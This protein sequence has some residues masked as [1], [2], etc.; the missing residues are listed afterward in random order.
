MNFRTHVLVIGGGPA[1][2]VAA[3]FLASHGVDTLLVERNLAFVKPCGGGIPYSAFQEL[4][5]PEYPVKR[6]VSELKVVSPGGETLNITLNGGSIAIVERGDFDRALRAEAEA[7]GATILEAEFMGFPDT[8][9]TVTA[10]V[11]SR[12]PGG[13]LRRMEVRAD[14]VIAA[15]GVNSRVRAATNIRP[16]PCFLTLSERIRGEYSDA[17]E[18]WFGSSHA[19][20]SYSWVFPMEGGVSAGTGAFGRAGIRGL[21][22][23]FKARRDLKS[24]GQFRGYR[25]PLWQGDLFHSGRILFAGDAAGHVMPFTC[26]GIYYSMK[27]GEMAA[28]AVM[29]G[30]PADYKRM[31]QERFLSRF[32]LMKRL[33]AYFLKGDH[34]MERVVLLHKRPEV[35]EAAMALWLRKDHGKGSL[36]SYMN[37]LRSFLT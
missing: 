34:R 31:W 10:L 22:Q 35:Q 4:G 19:P 32:S 26:E 36:L 5:I 14:Y 6:Y 33:W 21:W 7:A 9:R 37:L 24:G 12:N 30:R 13:T 11:V 23:R 15:D 16:S 2:A 17:C 25:I 20:R 28:T 3:R 1:G 8:G 27:S 18:F 29:A